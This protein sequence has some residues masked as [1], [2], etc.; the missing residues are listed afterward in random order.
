MSVALVMG[1]AGA[2]CDGS[3]LARADAETEVEVGVD[4]SPETEVGVEEVG[5]VGDEVEEVGVEIE[6]VGVDVI[7][8]SDS[9]LD[10]SDSGLDDSD[11]GLDDSDSGLDDSDSELDDSDSELDDSGLDDSGL[12]DS[13]LDDSG[14]DDTF[15]DDTFVD[16]TLVDDTLVDDTLVD[17]TL[18]DDT[19]VDDTLADDTLVD[20]TS[21]GDGDAA[22]EVIVGP[23]GPLV[24][25]EDPLYAG[26]VGLSGDALRAA[27]LDLVDDAVG[28]TYD[29]ARDLMYITAQIDVASDGAIECIYTGA[30]E[31]ADGTRSPGVITTE[32]SWPRSDGAGAFPAEGDMHHL[33]PAS[34]DSNNR[35]SNDEFGE[36]ACAET[37]VPTCPW[38]VGG[39]F[40]GPAV[41]GRSKVFEVRAAYRGDIARAHFYFAVRYARPIPPLEEATLRAWHCEDP[42]D[43]VERARNDGIALWQL[44]RNPFVDQP[45]LVE[46]LFDF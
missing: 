19:F 35:R 2:G 23:C 43:D 46:R 31:P 45:Q 32:H 27:L 1:I 4:A 21:L 22:A 11:S 29:Q 26:I 13:G 9:G 36:V 16:D 17:D 24:T 12:D 8:D 28:F 25:D 20:D 41:D 3:G 33:F 39:S 14:L 38:G 15:V 7:D 6:E 44:N 5:D 37:P 42:V 30:R 34:A 18:V 10:D 40:S